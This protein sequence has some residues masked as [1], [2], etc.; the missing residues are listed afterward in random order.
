M[1]HLGETSPSDFPVEMLKKTNSVLWKSK[2]NK[3]DPTDICQ[4]EEE[5]LC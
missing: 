5:S 2:N 1:K 3:R 4:N